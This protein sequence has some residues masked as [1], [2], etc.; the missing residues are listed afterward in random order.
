MFLQDFIKPSIWLDEDSSAP[1][2]GT[3]SGE[4]GLAP[5]PETDPGTP[6]EPTGQAWEPKREVAIVTGASDSDADYRK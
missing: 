6:A 5:T 3:V 2:T 1:M 4:G